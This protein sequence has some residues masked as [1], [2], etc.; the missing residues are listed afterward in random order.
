MRIFLDSCILFGAVE[1]RRLERLLHRCRN[2][3]LELHTSIS[4]IGETFAL[5]LEEHRRNEL[6]EIVEICEALDIRYG[7][8]WHDFDKIYR[9]VLAVESDVRIHPNDYIHLAHAC[10]VQADIFLTTDMPVHQSRNIGL[11]L[12]VLTPDELRSELKK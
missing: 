8:G 10:Y 5:C 7:H 9:M 11:L 12:R 6:H 2:L 1:D 4:V 3:G